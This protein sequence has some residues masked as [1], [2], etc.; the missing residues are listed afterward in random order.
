MPNFEY[1]RVLCVVIVFIEIP[2][3]WIISAALCPVAIRAHMS[4]SRGV[5]PAGSFLSFSVIF[6]RALHK[7]FCGKGSDI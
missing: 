6:R 3:S 1:A 2:W 4:A 7:A 5:K